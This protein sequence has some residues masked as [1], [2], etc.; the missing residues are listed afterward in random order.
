VKGKEVEISKTVKPGQ[1]QT[2]ETTT[3]EETQR[4]RMANC[5]RKMKRR[6]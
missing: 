2:R 3:K 6:R 5:E 4:R 1:S